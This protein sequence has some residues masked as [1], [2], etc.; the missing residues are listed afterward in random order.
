MC[1]IECSGAAI[2][3]YSETKGHI[4]GCQSVWSTG[5]ST[6]AC[7]KAARADRATT[8]QH[9]CGNEGAATRGRR[10]AAEQE[11]HCH[12]ADA[13]MLRRYKARRSMRTAHCSC[14]PVLEPFAA[15]HGCSRAAVV[16]AGCRARSVRRQARWLG[17]RPS[18]SLHWGRDRSYSRRARGSVRAADKAGSRHRCGASQLWP[19]SLGE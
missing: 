18:H 9:R 2:G 6:G 16:S 8:T 10:S 15:R 7:A 3:W 19:R 17:C 4:R 1:G 13:A 5:S 12:D 14:P 11:G